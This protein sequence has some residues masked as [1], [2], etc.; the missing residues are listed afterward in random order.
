MSRPRK[1]TDD[2]IFAAMHR[3]MT[4]VGPTELTLAAIAAEA[5]LTAGALVQRFGSKRQMLLAVTR[6]M[7]EGM[8]GMLADV[9]ALDDT[10]LEA[11]RAWAVCFAQLAE[12]PAAMAR[13]LA[14]LQNDLTD[15]DFHA[16][17]LKQYRATRVIYRTLLDEAMAEGTLAR[18]TDTEALARAVEVSINGSLMTWAVYQDGP[19]ARWI[20]TD[21]D[22]VLRPYVVV[23]AS[24]ATRPARRR[25]PQVRKR[26]R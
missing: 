14:Y 25:S 9:R 21:L 16:H 23:A 4:R 7:A 18:G 5:G 15:P 11:L 17:L 19:A 13:N 6:K 8:D 3:V 2:E 20:R 24:T 26:S 22:A 12:S 1:A 10:P